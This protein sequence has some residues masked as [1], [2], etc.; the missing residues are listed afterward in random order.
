M[1]I[2]VLALL[3]VIV[4]F[5]QDKP[6]RPI[7]LAGG[8]IVDVSAFG[9]STADLRDAVVVVEH[10]RITAAGPRRSTMIPR[11][12]EV[13]DATGK[14]IVPGLHDVFATINNQAYASAFLYMGVTAIV[15]NDTEDSRRGALFT[16]GQPSPRIYKMRD[17]QGRDPAGLEPPP[18]TIADLM[19]RGRKMD[20]VELNAHVDELARGGIK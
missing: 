11:G 1:R 18:R 3:G 16:G 13:I 6:A 17:V 4:G 15:A 12:A 2:A 8:T 10:G 7:A 14:F 9:S 19:A 5:V 20:A